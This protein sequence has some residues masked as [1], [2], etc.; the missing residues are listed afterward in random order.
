MYFLIAGENCFNIGIN[1]SLCSRNLP[2]RQSEFELKSSEE[3]ESDAKTIVN[4]MITLGRD[5]CVFLLGER[6]S[7]T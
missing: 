5:E 1:F 4:E 7:N 2:M 6:G 3:T